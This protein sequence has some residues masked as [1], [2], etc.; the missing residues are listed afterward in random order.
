MQASDDYIV[1]HKADNND[2]VLFL[3]KGSSVTAAAKKK[4]GCMVYMYVLHPLQPAFIV[5]SFVCYGATH[6]SSLTHAD[7]SVWF[8]N[9]G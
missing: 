1:N 5:L 3:F 8:R 9:S 7:C 6:L 4:V 2:I